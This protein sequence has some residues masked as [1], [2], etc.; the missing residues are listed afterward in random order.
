MKQPYS[1]Q[2]L[3][4]AIKLDNTIDVIEELLKRK[5]NVNHASHHASTSLHYAVFKGNLEV[6]KL[7][8]RNNANATLEDNNGNT[9]ISLAKEL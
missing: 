6:V 4:Q 9:P 5:A 3:F 8:L 2:L 1:Y 7:L